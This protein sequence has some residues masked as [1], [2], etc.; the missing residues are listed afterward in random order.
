MLLGGWDAKV[1]TK[2][3]DG[4][5]CVAASGA[6]TCF[7]RDVLDQRNPE[8]SIEVR[9]EVKEALRCSDYKVSFIA[10]NRGM[11]DCIWPL[12]LEDKAHTTL[13]SSDRECHFIR[14]VKLYDDGVNGVKPGVVRQ[15][16]I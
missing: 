6:K 5:C 15:E 7:A 11:C 2:C 3:P 14:E 12:I 9:Y 13:A 10:W 4:H 1:I 16:D 8:R